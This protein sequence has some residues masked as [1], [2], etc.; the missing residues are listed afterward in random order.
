MFRTVIAALGGLALIGSLTACTSAAEPVEVGPNTIIIDVRTP[1]ETASGYLEG[2]ELIDFNA[3]EFA[4]A[5]PSLDPE[6]EY[7]VYCRSGNRAGQAIALMEQNGFE[8]VTNLGSLQ[9]AADSTGIA[10]VTS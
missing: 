3:G 4:A 10:V 8:N 9:Q 2:A 6:A 7:L 5:L 1:E